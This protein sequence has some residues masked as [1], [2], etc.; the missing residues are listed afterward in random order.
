[1]KITLQSLLYQELKNIN[2]KNWQKIKLVWAK[3]LGYIPKNSEI[4]QA[5]HLLLEKQKIKPLPKITASLIVRKIRTL[6][7]VAPFAVMMKPFLCPGKCIYCPQEPGMPKS[8]LSDEPAAARAKKLNFDPFLQINSRLKQLKAIGHQP[9]KLQI[10]VIG[11][12]FSAYPQEYKKQFLKNIFDA[13]NG[14]VAKNISQAQEWNQ[15]AKHRIIGLSI[16]TRPDW[17]DDKELKLLRD[18]GVTK[19]QLGVQA[20]DNKINKITQ[21]G[22]NIEAVVKATDKLRNAGFK[23]NYHFM[24]NL[25]GSNPQKDISMAKKMFSSSHFRPD[26]LKI[27]PCIVIAKTKLFSLWQ[28]GKYQAYDDKTLINVLSEIKKTVP[29]YCRIDRLV[30]DISRKWTRAG[31]TSTNI[32]QIIKK[33]MDKSL[34]KCRCI[35]CREVRNQAKLNFKVKLKIQKYQAGNG[36]EIFLSFKDD[37]Y[38]Y[39]LLRLRLPNWQK[40]KPLFPVLKNSALIRGIQV[41]GQQLGIGNKVKSNSPQHQ[42]LGKQLIKKAEKLAYKAGY[43]K[44]AIISGVGVRGYYQ[45]LGY[46]LQQTYMVK[47]VFAS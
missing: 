45:K 14:K 3:S 36:Q 30:R 41:F 21:R 28:K 9:E 32:R 11:G 22:H 12:T 27:Y 6:S 18:Y 37:K 24:P 31:T 26:T 40:T 8:Y 23:I 34:E 5:Y 35:R 1:M 4:L 43:K 39:A 33:R 17:L 10:I 13:V 29:Y 7:G 47:K 19:V 16:E 2:P 44:M 25:P 42:Q 38:L 15:K 20:L 46:H